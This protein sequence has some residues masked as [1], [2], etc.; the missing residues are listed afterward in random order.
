LGFSSD[1]FEDGYIS[2]CKVGFRDI[3]FEALFGIPRGSKPASS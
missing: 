1:L 3:G 2:F